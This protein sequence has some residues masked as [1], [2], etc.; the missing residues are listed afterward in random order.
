MEFLSTIDWSFWGPLLSIFILIC[1][2]GFFSG[3]E[4]ALTAVSKARMV[5]LEKDGDKRAGVVNK[6][7]DEK[8]RLIGSLLLGNNLVNILA[9]AI[10]TSFFIK[11]V[12]E[13]GV[14]YATLVMTVVVLIFA[15]VLPKTYALT[16]SDKMALAIAP[17]IRVMVWLF[18]PVTYLISKIVN[19]ALKVVGGTQDDVQMADMAVQEL[20]GAID[21]AHD[22][23]E[24]EGNKESSEK[25][26]M[27]R[28]ILDL[29]DVD[30]ED[31]MTHRSNVLALDGD[32]HV[33]EI[34]DAVLDSP[35]TRIPVWK[36]DK[37]N[38]IGIVHAKILLR[39]LRG[40]SGDVS[41]LAI[42]DLLLEP[43]FVPETTTLFD[44]LQ[45][46]RER[47]E[48]F[49][50]VVDEYGAFQ[51][52][53]TLEDVLE[54]IVGEIDDEQDAETSGI[55]TLDNGSYIVDGTVTVRDLNR[56]LDWNLPDEDYTTIAGLII[57]ESK[58]VPEKGQSFSF[59]DCRFEIL[60]R[61]RNQITSL[62]ITP[63]AR[64]E[65]E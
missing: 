53:V 8:D 55:V 45:A 10:A 26:A 32:L 12:G 35:Y 22:T 21:L 33:A 41:K 38:I 48:H 64:E 61:E 6:L 34:V 14:V 47:K 42:S 40:A 30:V 13:T 60:E 17:I 4:T 37:D 27:L 63:P 65:D 59:F 54:E 25:R 39:E 11:L 9:S 23:A 1:M 24:G 28:S 7:T 2:S 46:F 15:E 62:R 58:M 57:Y 50:I 3:S 18:T 20:R 29:V 31:V 43:W 5:T 56:E 36:D 51:G 44:Q 49:A 52:I 19:V 16:H